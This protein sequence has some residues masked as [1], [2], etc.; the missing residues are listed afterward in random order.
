MAPQSPSAADVAGAS[1]GRLGATLKQAVGKW[2]ADGGSRLGAALAYYTVFSIAPLLV[3]AIGVAGLVFGEQAARGEIVDQ[4]EERVGPSV[5]GFVEDILAGSRGGA[6]VLATVTGTVLAL[7]AA[8]GLF[9]QLTG[10]LNVVWDVPASASKGLLS[11]FRSRWLAF[12]SVLGVGLLLIAVLAASSVVSALARLV[13]EDLAFL[14]PVVQWL[15]PLVMVALLAAVFALVFMTLP[16]ARTQWRFAWRGGFLTAVLFTIG[17]V[18][19]GFYIGSGAVGKGFGVS[20]SLVAMLVYAYYSAQIFLLGA[21]FTRVLGL[22]AEA[23]AAGEGDLSSEL[24][25]Q[26]RFRAVDSTPVVAIWAFLAGL[27]VGWWKRRA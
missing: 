4:I 12:L 15:S 13:P 6:G 5:A 16:D 18:L 20:A 7:L 26:T 3:V 25:R 24:P 27:A 14:A 8:S 23:G 17:T 1:R 9:M 19:L 2:S 10:A 21:E 11:A 22:R